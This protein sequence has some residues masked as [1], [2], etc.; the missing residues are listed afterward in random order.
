[1]GPGRPQ[2][3]A[4][5]SYDLEAI[6]TLHSWLQYPKFPAQNLTFPQLH[7][8]Y[9]SPSFPGLTPG[10]CGT[11]RSSGL[12][13]FCHPQRTAPWKPARLSQLGLAPRNILREGALR[14]GLT[15][16]ARGLCQESWAESGLTS[17]PLTSQAS[18]FSP[19]RCPTYR[20]GL[21]WGS[22]NRVQGAAIL[23]T[24]P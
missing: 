23:N 8:T 13:R 9:D 12:S 5:Q 22:N 2:S 10:A 17:C 18:A 14:A 11:S 3:S 19:A 21:L 20:Q 16:R 6:S 4:H 1:M 15:G 7:L 24:R